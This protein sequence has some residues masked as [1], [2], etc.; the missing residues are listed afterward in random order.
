MHSS[1]QV[2]HSC[3]QVEDAQHQQCNITLVDSF[4][5]TKS[6]S[7]S[8][9]YPLLL[10]TSSIGSCIVLWFA[11]FWNCWWDNLL[12]LSTSVWM[13]PYDDMFHLSTAALKCFLAHQTK[14]EHVGLPIGIFLF[15]ISLNFYSRLVVSQRMIW[16]M[17]VGPLVSIQESMSVVRL[18]KPVTPAQGDVSEIYDV[19]AS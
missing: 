11:K 2:H 19:Y 13:C 17:C 10:L 4:A 16:I 8:S 15:T 1:W 12:H 7:C 9:S 5:T 14:G 6:P 3:V 18:T